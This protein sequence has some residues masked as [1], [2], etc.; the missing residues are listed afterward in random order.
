MWSGLRVK[1]AMDFWVFGVLSKISSTDS[2]LRARVAR[3]APFLDPPYLGGGGKFGPQSLYVLRAGRPA[4]FAITPSLLSNSKSKQILLCA[5][6]A[7]H[8]P[9]PPT[10]T[11]PTQII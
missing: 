3:P 8:L 10:T 6:L 5:D 11:H 2:S 4:I 7:F 9:L 1:N